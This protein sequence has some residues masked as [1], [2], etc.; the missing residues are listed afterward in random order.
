MQSKLMQ[1]LMVVACVFA[2]SGAV[3]ADSC[4]AATLDNYLG[5]G[6][7]CGIDDKTFSNFQYSYSSN[8]G[9]FGIPPG[10]VAVTPITTPG[11]PGLQ[12]SAGWFASTGSGILEED[13]LIQYQV[14]VNP[15]GNL[16]TD[17]SL[18]IAGGGFSGTGAVFVDE[19][20]CLGAVLPACTG[21]EIVTLSVYDSSAGSKLFDEVTFAGVSEIS[22]AKDITVQAG[23]D[24]S[25]RL[26]LVTNQFSEGGQVPEPSSIA[27]FGTGVLGLAGL[28]RRKLNR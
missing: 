18:S 21:G 7:S 20:A 23:T 11:N 24:G 12:F 22:L 9:G 6:Y 19:T 2:L 15:G 5:S 4:P 16:I 17:L 13:S 26:S 27:L 28:L 8:P 14:D 10:G 3:F 25:A 1:V